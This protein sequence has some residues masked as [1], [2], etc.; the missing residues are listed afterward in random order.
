VFESF[1]SMASNTMNGMDEFFDFDQLEHDHGTQSTTVFGIRNDGPFC[2]PVDVMA[3][4][5]ATSASGPSP[6]ECHMQSAF[7]SFAIQ[8][9]AQWP[10]AGTLPQN[11]FEG[12]S[13][14]DAVSTSHDADAD[15]AIAP[16]PSNI[17]PI[18]GA[19]PL[20]SFSPLDVSG[21]SICEDVGMIDPCVPEGTPQ[22]AVQ[23]T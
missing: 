16:A 1:S 5:W 21:I 6:A 3:M 14:V 22:S 17:P 12:V 11:L 15:I 18:A 8:D 2:D 20:S 10:L 4:D 23:V 19:A 9:Q 13:I 7:D